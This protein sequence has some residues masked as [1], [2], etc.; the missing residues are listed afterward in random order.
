MRERGRNDEYP[1][2]G[3]RG[4]FL[5]YLLVG[6]WNT[7]FGYGVFAGFTYL[8]TPRIPRAYLV[9]TV[10][11][12]ILSVTV[13]YFGYKLFV[14]KT[15]GNYLREYLRCYVVY[16]SSG[17]VNLALL[18]L[19]VPCC[20]HLI[21]THRWTL[22]NLAG[23]TLVLQQSAAPYLAALLLLGITVIASF[24]GHRN[25]SFRADRQAD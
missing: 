2:R 20:A 4:Q 9:A 3:S 6:A 23:S 13:A 11:S 7:L 10:I 21:G 25:F 1:E 5:R 18:P 12:T 24:F 22:L 16:G 8:L 15:K 17:L 14:F 19:L